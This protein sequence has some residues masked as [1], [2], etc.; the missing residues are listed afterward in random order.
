MKIEALSDVIFCFQ[1]ETWNLNDQFMIHTAK[2]VDLWNDDQLRVFRKSESLS[3]IHDSFV[4]SINGNAF[5]TKKEIDLLFDDLKR[6]SYNFIYLKKL[7]LNMCKH[8]TNV[9]GISHLVSLR[10]IDLS[11]CLNINNVDSITKLTRLEKLDLSTCG[12]IQKANF[13]KLTNLIELKFKKNQVVE[14]T[15]PTSLQRLDMEQSLKLITTMGF[16]KA[17]NLNSLNLQNCTT[18]ININ[19]LSTLT[20]LKELFLTNCTSLKSVDPLVTLTNIMTL[21]MNQ[22]ASLQNVNCI[23]TLTKLTDLELCNCDIIQDVSGVS[24]LTNLTSL[25]ISSFCIIQEVN[26]SNLTR[27]KR[28]DLFGV[29]LQR[30]DGLTNL[31]NLKYLNINSCTF[32]EDSALKDFMKENNLWSLYLQGQQIKDLFN[33]MSCIRRKRKRDSEKQTSSKRTKRSQ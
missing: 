17:T 1:S 28:L 2:D 20:N 8:I 23:S 32:S 7:K 29:K 19:H 4:G 30:I 25:I 18:L 9:N 5:L 12:N 22:C 11:M 27:L 6:R 14:I 10:D 21:E 26:V 13:E 33:A 16:E 31:T 24:T 15:L 3:A